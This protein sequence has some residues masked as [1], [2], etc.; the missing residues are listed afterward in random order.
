VGT[1]SLFSRGTLKK[2]ADA[3]DYTNSGAGLRGL[4]REEKQRR[5]FASFE[6]LNVS[7]SGVG[8]GGIAY[9]DFP[10][11]GGL[12]AHCSDKPEQVFNPDRTAIKR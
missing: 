11:R 10:V 8:G 12:G 3:Q 6:N 7:L 2:I 4:K 9:L 1:L 5:K